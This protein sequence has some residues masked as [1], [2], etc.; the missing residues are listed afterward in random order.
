MTQYSGPAMIVHE[1]TNCRDSGSNS[2]RG[3]VGGGAMF[4]RTLNVVLL[5]L[6]AVLLT[7]PAF[8]DSQVRI[9]RLSQVR[10]A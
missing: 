5:T 6:A 1:A 3:G 4:R 8:A 9:V 2:L 7:L 10:R